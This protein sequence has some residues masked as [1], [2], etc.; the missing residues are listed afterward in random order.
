[1]QCI[2]AS[3]SAKAP[4]TVAKGLTAATM[5]RLRQC[6]RPGPSKRHVALDNACTVQRRREVRHANG[7]EHAPIDNDGN[8]DR[9]R[10]TRFDHWVAFGKTCL[11]IVASKTNAQVAFGSQFVLGL[12]RPCQHVERHRPLAD[13]TE[14][15]I[16]APQRPLAAGGKA[17]DKMDPSLLLTNSA[18]SWRELLSALKAKSDNMKGI[19]A[20]PT[21]GFVFPD[22]ERPEPQPR[23]PFGPNSV[24]LDEFIKLTELPIQMVFGD[25]TGSRPIFVTSVKPAGTLSDIVNCRGGDCG[26]LQLPDAGLHGNS[27]IGFN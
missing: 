22:G 17:I 10:P 25:Y 13:R 7:G 3:T 5:G 15:E 21:P 2:L 23:A 12:L 18:G 27:H 9:A 11:R 24:P 16:G 8:S 20:S 6:S 26:L 4:D 1:M 19:I 14:G